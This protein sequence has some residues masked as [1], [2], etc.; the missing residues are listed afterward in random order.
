MFIAVAQSGSSEEQVR[1]LPR[2]Q[3][4]VRRVDLSGHVMAESATFIVVPGN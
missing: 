4:S 2:S 3:H 1:C